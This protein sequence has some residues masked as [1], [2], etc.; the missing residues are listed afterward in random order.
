MLQLLNRLPALEALS[1]PNDDGQSQDQ[2]LAGSLVPVFDH[3]RALTGSPLAS[4][5]LLQPFVQLL[6][7]A[8][9]EYRADRASG[10]ASSLAY[11]AVFSLAP[12][13]LLA[14]GVAGFVF[15]RDAAEGLIVEQLQDTVGVAAATTIQDVL[16]S[17]RDSRLSATG[18]GLA[19]AVF[20]GSGVFLALEDSLNFVFRA[21]ASHTQGLTAAVR[22]RFVASAAAVSIGVVVL[23]LLGAGA[24]V[25]W[26]GHL[27]SGRG[28]V[29]GIQVGGLAVSVLAMMLAI[30][31][32]FQYLTAVRLP[33]RAVW[34]GAALT[35]G[36]VQIT[37]LG[38]GLYVKWA[39]TNS[40]WAAVGGVAVVLFGAYTLARAF[41]LGAEF[42]KVYAHRLQG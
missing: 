2:V 35:A 20:A 10:A 5:H 21:P 13:L 37:A 38:V 7:A 19:L 11:H 14:V 15:G 17:A 16:E 31:L 12:L 39:S 32:M 22:K 6:K 36:L 4:P 3:P 40:T 8:I 30:G 25:S 29:I 28:S 9:K 34:R 24:L 33:W 27:L 26:A 42:T 23:G 18:I 41:L 1:G